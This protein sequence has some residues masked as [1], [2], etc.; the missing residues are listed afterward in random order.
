M[1]S[2]APSLTAANV[3][4]TCGKL[5]LGKPTAVPTRPRKVVSANS[6]RAEAYAHSSCSEER[7]QVPGWNS[8]GPRNQPRKMLRV[9][10][11]DRIPRPRS[12]RAV[13]TLVVGILR[14]IKRSDPSPPGTKRYPRRGHDPHRT[15]GDQRLLNL[16]WSCRHI[17]LECLSIRKTFPASLGMTL[18][19][20]REGLVVH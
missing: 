15:V 6:A 19:P 2:R 9:L 1:H 16:L 8:R 13:G 10:K 5:P 17:A 11:H 3:S 4:P 7:S 12:Q 20:C 14:L 18:R